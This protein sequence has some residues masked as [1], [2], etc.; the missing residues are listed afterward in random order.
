[1][2]NQIHLTKS[3][4]ASLQNQL[5]GFELRNDGS[6]N[7]CLNLSYQPQPKSLTEAITLTQGTYQ[8]ISMN[9][10]EVYSMEIGLK[11]SMNFLTREMTKRSNRDSWLR[12][13]NC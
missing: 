8:P 11:L 10:K 3:L 1:M 2:L 7:A 13:N 9:G 5:L 4:Q 6:Q 12:S